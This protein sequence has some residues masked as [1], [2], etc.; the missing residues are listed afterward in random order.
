M[1]ARRLDL[2]GNRLPFKDNYFTACF[3]GE[4]FEHIYDTDKLAKEVM[5]ILK[6][7]GYVVVT[8]PNIASWYNRLFLLAGLL[9][10]YVES[11]SIGK[12]HG[13][14][15]YQMEQFL[16]SSQIYGHLKAFTKKSVVNLFKDNGFEIEKVRGSP[17]LSGIKLFDAMERVF[18]N[19]TSLS[20]TIIV[21]ARKPLTV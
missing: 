17:L 2:D 13:T 9:P 18:S 5:R 19:F 7:G 8:V 15:K 14:K 21:K 16:R 1:K 12:S 20:T 4:T 10:M 3:S 11:R 6:P